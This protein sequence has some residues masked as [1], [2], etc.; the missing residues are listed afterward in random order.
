MA[1]SVAYLARAFVLG[2][3][4]LAVA[5]GE[6][7]AISRGTSVRRGRGTA[8]MLYIAVCVS[9][10]SGAAASTVRLLTPNPSAP[11]AIAVSSIHATG[12][13]AS[14][15]ITG[16][17]TYFGDIGVGESS[18]ASPILR[19][20]CLWDPSGVFIMYKPWDGLPERYGPVIEIDDFAV[21]EVAVNQL[22]A[23]LAW[24]QDRSFLVTP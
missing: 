24:N 1:E 4:G 11:F 9:V 14:G 7:V 3:S 22:G 17:C 21:Y 23:R 8:H 16:H 19:L 10:S 15:N 5:S 2:K 12:F 6:A 20:N 18:G 13:D